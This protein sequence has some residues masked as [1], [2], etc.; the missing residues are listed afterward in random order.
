MALLRFKPVRLMS[1]RILVWVMAVFASALSAS[2]SAAEF[3]NT[4]YRFSYTPIYQFETDLDGDGRFDVQRHFFRFDV[5]RPVDRHWMVGLGVSVDYERWNFEDISGLAGIDLW[6]E[7]FRPGISIPIFY[8]ADGNWRFGFIPSID[9]A[10]AT[11]AEI[12]E[13]LSYG[14]VLSAA[15]AVGPHLT[16]GVGTGIFNRLD[17]SDVFPFIVV[18][19]KLSDRWR[20]GNPFRAGPVGPAGLELTY[21]PNAR[22]ELGIGGG[23]R[24]YRFRLDDSSAVADG[25]G[26]VDFLAPF[27]RV[28]WR[29]GSCCQVDVNG[30]ALV[31]GTISIEDRDGNELGDVDYDTAPFVGITFRGRF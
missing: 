5:T 29:L 2:G 7:L 21:T 10:G 19:W 1:S 27:L 9:V 16:I 8:R 23:Y 17:Q 15:Y 3:R 26:Q 24:S 6:D 11:G 14:A 12:D 31:D 25:I 20:L 30:G 22:M 18:D 4:S 13:S 28:G